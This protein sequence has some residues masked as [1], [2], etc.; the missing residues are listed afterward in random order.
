[1]TSLSVT[2][3]HVDSVYQYTGQPNNGLS[4]QGFSV[5]TTN[6]ATA[7][8]SSDTRLQYKHLLEQLRSIGGGLDVVG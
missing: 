7:C 6:A 3:H 8:I 5:T 1:M 4:L 2:H